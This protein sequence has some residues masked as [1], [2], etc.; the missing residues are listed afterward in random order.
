MDTTKRFGDR[1]D[2]YIKYRPSYPLEIVRILEREA[3]IAPNE[4]RVCDIGSGTG[5][6]AELF[7]REGYEVVGVEPN[8]PMREASVRLLAKYPKFRAIDGTA[9]DTKQTNASFGL[10]I[11]AQAFHWFDGAHARTEVARI[12]EPKGTCALVWNLRRSEGAFLEAYEDA[13]LRWATDYAKVR[14]E[15]VE[16]EPIEKFFRGPHVFRSVPNHQDFDLE[17]LLGRALS[18]SYVPKS[19]ANHDALMNAL[20]EMF[21]RHQKNGRVRFDYDTKM[22]FGPLV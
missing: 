21:A 22:W 19:G 4:T 14:H 9:E 8:A 2:D 11:A 3:N 17:G 12:L 16:G 6:S 15:N 13:L 18:S 1:V 10:V 5:I 7:L 20:R